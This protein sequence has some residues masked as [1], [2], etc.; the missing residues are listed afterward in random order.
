[1]TGFVAKEGRRNHQTAA[2][3]LREAFKPVMLVSV[4]QH[5]VFII[6]CCD[7][8]KPG[9]CSQ[10]NVTGRF[11]VYHILLGLVRTDDE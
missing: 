1:M 8:M 2:E 3:S 6:M 11:N 10:C 9:K 7:T 4:K 5:T